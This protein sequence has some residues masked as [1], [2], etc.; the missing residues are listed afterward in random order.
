[1]V[2]LSQREDGTYSTGHYRIADRVVRLVAADEWS[3]RISESFVD[4]FYFTRLP[5]PF[6]G[7]LVFDVIVSSAAAPSLPAGLKS[8]SVPHGQCYVEGEGFHLHVDDSFIT[9]APP[10]LKR[11]DVWFGSTARARRPVAIVNV[12]AYAL[13]AA[14]R[15]SRLYDLHA[16]GVVEPATGRGF[17]FPGFS[18]SGKSSLTVRLAG[19]GW[20]Y[21]SDD[22]L[23]LEETD[24]GVQA[25]GLRRLF[26]V[27]AASIAACRPARL[28]EA[29]GTPVASDP[30][31]RRLDPAIAFP[32]GRAESCRPS[33]ICFPTITGESESRLRA[34]GQ[35]EAM[36]QLIRLCPW[37]G[38]DVSS[39]RGNLAVLSRLAR[40]AKSFLLLA[41]R[42][43][44]DDPSLAP[45]L[46]AETF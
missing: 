21:L 38:Y 25:R 30:S 20:R 43:I 39:S 2:A 33:V 29:L 34:I 3:A 8:F 13:Q 12:M 24:G 14:L 32:E 37:A 27:S 9:V 42:D 45:R 11:V 6:P 19:S 44:L 4:S 10:G 23:V 18:N 28:D 16:A 15:R 36:A 22:M 26:S 46:L 7:S 31:K 1:M 41:G 17:I 40:Q 5:E 35:P